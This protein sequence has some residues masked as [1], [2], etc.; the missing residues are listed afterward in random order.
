MGANELLA[1]L[2][3]EG[4]VNEAEGLLENLSS[5]DYP[6]PGGEGGPEPCPRVTTPLPLVSS[7]PDEMFLDSP[8]NSGE[9]LDPKFFGPTLPPQEEASGKRCTGG[10]LAGNAPPQVHPKV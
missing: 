2:A 8:T 6:A 7:T 5:L 10:L 4:I 3:R 1:I 9:F